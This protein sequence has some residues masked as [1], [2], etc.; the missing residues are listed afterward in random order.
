MI[1]EETNIALDALKRI[2]EQVPQSG[3]ARLM[4]KWAKEA[5]DKIVGGE[6][7]DNS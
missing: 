7:D 4:R 2:I 3:Q 5:Y 1:T 6:N